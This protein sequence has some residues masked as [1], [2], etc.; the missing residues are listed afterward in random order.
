MKKIIWFHKLILKIQHILGSHGLNGHVHFLTTP[1][2]KLLKQLLAFLILH[3]QVKNQF[4]LSIHSWDTVNYRVSRPNQPHPF[5]SMPVQKCFDQ[6]LIY[7]ILYQHCKKSGY[8]IDLLWGYG[9]SKNHV[10]WLAENISAHISGKK[11]FSK[12]EQEH[13]K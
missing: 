8:F 4:I 2:Q 10:I 9:W 7:V 5:L 12:Y 13:R 11:V 1:T 6:I 3:Q